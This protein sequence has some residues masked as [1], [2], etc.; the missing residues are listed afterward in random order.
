MCNMCFVDNISV[1]KKYNDF[2]R[3]SNGMISSDSQYCYRDIPLTLK[4]HIKTPFPSVT[5]QALSVSCDWTVTVGNYQQHSDY[6]AMAAQSLCCRQFSTVTTR[7][8]S[9][10]SVV[11]K[12]SMC[13]YK[14]QQILPLNIQ[15]HYNPLPY[16]KVVFTHI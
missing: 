14:A 10:H 6:T 12:C 5:Q 11:T 2:L 9:S 16:Q 8:L 7:S 13:I 4:L 15:F 3:F 1:I